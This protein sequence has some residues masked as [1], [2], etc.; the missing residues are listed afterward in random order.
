MKEFREIDLKKHIDNRGAL[1]AIEGDLDIPFKIKRIFYIYGTKG[2]NPRGNHANRRSEFVLI[3]LA[4]KCKVRVDDG[5][6]RQEVYEL[7]APDF[8][9]YIP[10][11]C[12]KEMYD[13]SPDAV[14]LVLAS[15]HYDPEEYIYSYEE[16]VDSIEKR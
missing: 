4:G 1:V 3:N 8:G 12:W 2:E 5:K 13:F 6:G 9:I 7:L 11:M 15:E 16:F 10:N 14:L